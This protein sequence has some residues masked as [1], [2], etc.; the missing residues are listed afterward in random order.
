MRPRTNAD[1]KKEKRPRTNEGTSGIDAID[2][3]DRFR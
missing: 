1:D 3:K 2:D